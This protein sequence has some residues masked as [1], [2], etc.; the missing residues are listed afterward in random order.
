V[1]LRHR[2]SG[3]L[4]ATVESNR[5]TT[6]FGHL[7]A[8]LKR[9]ALGQPLATREL[10]HERLTKVKA[11]AVFS[12]DALSSSAYAT[13]EILLVLILAG[14]AGLSMTVPIALAIGGL[15]AVVAFSYRQTIRAY[16]NGGGSYIVSKDNL[17]TWPAL[18]A[19]GALM[20]GYVLTV[21]V[22]ISAGV[23]A[24][25]SA[26][27]A[28]DA[29]RVE[30]ALGFIGLIT[31]INLRGIRESGSIFAIPTY[32]FIA[33]MGAMIALGVARYFLGGLEI[34][35]PSADSVPMTEAL[36]AVLVL[37]AFTSGCAAL[38]GTEAI[39]DG[40]P[41]F[42][43]PEWKNAQITLTWMAGILAVL[44]LGISFLA[45][46]LMIIPNHHE[47]VVS[48]IARAVFGE[49][50]FYYII[51][52]ATML[53]LVLAANTAFADFPRLAYFLARDHF[54]PH[55]FQFRGD[56]LAFSSG[57][58]A[59][60]LISAIVVLQFRADTHALIP[61]Y[62]ISVFIAFTMSESSM[63]RHWWV[64]REPGW[65]RSFVI[66]AIG[67]VV[68]GLVAVV[69]GV[70][71]FAEGAWMVLVMIPIFGIIMRAINAHY[72]S[73]ADQ[74]ALENT[75]EHP[76]PVPEPIVLVPVPGINRAVKR[77]LEVAQ[78]LSG[79]VTAIH[80]T[81]DAEAAARLRERWREWAPEVPLIV[82]ESPY[83]A[84]AGPLLAYINSI[85]RHDATTP[86][87]IVLAEYVPRHFWEYPLHNQTA[88]RLKLTLFFRP[89]TIVMDVPYHLAR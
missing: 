12:S 38:T 81:D 25:S 8:G 35:A 59:L 62:A 84:F 17:G 70:T 1:G 88:L 78:G 42:E 75:D 40:V 27:P 64:K 89:N 4:E 55:Q 13:E 43:P 61:L 56:R 34:V 79:R 9:L 23:A 32:F 39:S 69:A 20:I 87:V 14:I 41:A 3:T 6:P 52:V 22:S 58:M 49:S 33:S 47:T 83:R 7:L 53:S 48:Q 71:K 29:H 10:A 18:T 73:V 31:L 2:S 54:V 30:V 60:G 11:L 65:K 63:V 44:F 80:V 24:I 5:P 86:I 50:P 45:N 67:A 57:I 66:N 19:A 36:T 68:T 37:R 15:L 26:V 16:P 28:L 51:Q 82:L 85:Q 77:T 21:S 76:V 46:Q 72:V 74:L